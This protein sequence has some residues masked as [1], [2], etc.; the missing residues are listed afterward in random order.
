[1]YLERMSRID[2]QQ[3][4][5]KFMPKYVHSRIMVSYAKRVLKWAVDNEEI[6]FD[7]NPL[8]HVTLGKS[9]KAEKRETRYYTEEQAKRF[10]AGIREYWGKARPD[11]VALFTVL[12]RTGARIGEV[13]ALQWENVDFDN[14]VIELN[15]RVSTVGDKLEYLDGLKNGSARRLVEIDDVT[16]KVLKSWHLMQRV[17]YFSKGVKL[18]GSSL[19]FSSTRP[20]N[21]GKEL[22][23]SPKYASR[24]LRSFNTWYNKNHDAQ[25]PWLNVHG[26]RHTH[27]SLLLSHGMPLKQ[28]SDRL[29][30]KDI[31]VT[32]NIY[33]DVTPQ[34][35]REVADKFSQILA[36][37]N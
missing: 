15:G 20:A 32:A 14:A 35:K 36:N 33:A 24:V 22:L 26:F 1:M 10:E 34:A 5:N 37:S 28:V 31:T 3:R 2:I 23:K 27:A 8:D 9:K 18:K 19:L 16:V 25:L 17:A 21:Y 4:L 29:G 13:M 30:H 7:D 6:A 12:L 11:L